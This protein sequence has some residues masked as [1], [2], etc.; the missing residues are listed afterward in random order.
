M[1][2]W[3]TL[4]DL[5]RVMH[6]YAMRGLGC[7]FVFGLGIA[8][9]GAFGTALVAVDRNESLV[10]EDEERPSGSRGNAAQLRSGD[11]ALEWDRQ[12]RDEEA[13]EAARAAYADEY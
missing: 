3:S 11:V 5:V 7:L 12:R 2:V 13:E 6:G 9:L 10:A 8:A 4:F 1:W